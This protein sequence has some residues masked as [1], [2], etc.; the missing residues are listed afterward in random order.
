[1]LWRKGKCLANGVEIAWEESGSETGEPIV[2]VMGLGLQLIHWPEDLCQQ[3]VERGFRVIRFDNRDVGLSGAADNGIEVNMPRD[4]LRSR[5]GLPIKANYRLHD[6]AADTVGLLDAL[7]IG[8]AHLAGI[9]MG[10][11][12][13]QIASGL[14]P[15][16]VQSL[17]SIMS[18]TNER[19]LPGPKLNVLMHMSK[20]G[21]NP[22]R[23]SVIERSI[24]FF[25]MVGSPAYPSPDQRRA[26]MAGAAFDRAYR[27][28]GVLRQMHG[29]LATGGFSDISASIKAPTLIIHGKEDPLVRPEAGR[30]CAKVIP[31]ARLQLYKGMGHDFPAPLFPEWA[32]LIAQNAART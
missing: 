21:A 28:E 13:A 19:R 15:Q 10:G 18:T 29:I 30:R 1:M 16:R 8:K 3:L 5:I 11:M 24:K 22:T 27:P 6:M 32:E 7:G 20:T 9:S 26:D 31:N 25:N 12:I 14:Y 23:E 2:L 4:W 17:T